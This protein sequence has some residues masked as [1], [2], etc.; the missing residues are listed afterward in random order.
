VLKP[1][2]LYALNIID[3]RPLSLLRAEAASLLKVFKN[4]RLVTPA[5]EDGR[6]AGDN[7]ILFASNGPLPPQHGSP[8]ANATVFDR[9][10]IVSLVAGARSLT[11]DYAPVD[12]LQTR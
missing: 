4:L 6:P 5:G 8:V 11:D 1:N 3:L 7:A 2:G 12:Q 9:S 10:A